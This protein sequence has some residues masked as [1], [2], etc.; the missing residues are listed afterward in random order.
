MLD[1]YY[2][3]KTEFYES[4]FAVGNGY[5]LLFVHSNGDET[6]HTGE[7][8]DPR[9]IVTVYRQFDHTNLRLVHEGRHYSRSWSC[10]YGKRTILRLARAFL[11]DI[12]GT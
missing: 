12:V 9:G 4:D 5:C 2:Q 3:T 7:V 6:Y 8:Y 1:Q 11:T 10:Y